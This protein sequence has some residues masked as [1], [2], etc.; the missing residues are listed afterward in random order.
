[1]EKE[2]KENTSKTKKWLIPVVVVAVLLCSVG[3]Y[4]VYQKVVNKGNNY[5]GTNLSI[6][7]SK[8]TWISPNSSNPRN[9]KIDTISLQVSGAKFPIESYRNLFAKGKNYSCNYSVGYDGRVGMYVEEKNRSW[10]NGN[11]ANDNRAVTIILSSD[12]SYNVPSVTIDKLIIVM[13]DI[14]KRN[15]IEKLVWSDNREERINHTNGANVTIRND[16]MRSKTNENKLNMKN[17]V[18]RVNEKLGVN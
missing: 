2:K 14:C 16:F 10:C 15:G 18:N 1:M 17:I 8:E 7:I 11:S 12:S 6:N 9:H 13:A 3:G 5:G 4:F